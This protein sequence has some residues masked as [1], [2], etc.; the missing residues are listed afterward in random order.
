MKK[1]IIFLFLVSL[2]FKGF[3]QQ[4]PVYYIT[5]FLDITTN[6]RII[7]FG[8]V[9]V[10]SS[11]FY[12]NTGVYQNPALI[13]KNGRFS[14]GNII[15]IPWLRDKIDDLNLIGISGYYAIDSLNAFAL[16]YT[17][18]DMGNVMINNEYGEYGGEKNPF[19]FYLKLGYKHSFNKTISTGIA[20]KY[21][22]S[23]YYSS[24]YNYL[25]VNTFAV[26][27]GFN[28]DKKYRLNQNSFLNTS[29]GIAI[30]NFGPKV[31]YIEGDDKSFL[32]SKLS[33]GAFINP[34][35]GIKDKYRL[36]IEL[37][38]QIEKYLVASNE[39]SDIS[40]IEAL[41]VSFTDAPG[42]F[43]E[44]LDEIRHKF[45]SELRF[46][47]FDYG[48]VAFR[49]GRSV[50]NEYKGNRNYQTF[51]YGIGAFGFMLDFMNIVADS[52]SPLNKTWAFSFGF[53]ANLDKELFK[54]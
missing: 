39:N 21:Y 3:A 48:Y 18:L 43:E 27:V 19:E 15:Y 54:F 22:K 30:N 41:Y 50:E 2:I 24:Y 52:D 36:S 35:I 32:P 31:R 46:S 8:E 38:Y 28:Y 7:G 1:H 44:E 14:G 12:K 49:H 53:Q 33:V 25:T 34:D 40:S 11:P 26:D 47:I 6:S 37:G 5:P 45:G 20:I 16:N 23:E 13:S 10:V 51:G 4:A 29:A 17:Y 9:G 42:G